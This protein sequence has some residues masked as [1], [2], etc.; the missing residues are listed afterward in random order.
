MKQSEYDAT[1]KELE[2]ALAELKK[3]NVEPDNFEY[4]T[5][6]APYFVDA[7]GNVSSHRTRDMEKIG[8]AFN[9]KEHAQTKADYMLR[10]GKMQRLLI[11]F[12]DGWEPDWGSDSNK[13]IV[14]WDVYKKKWETSLIS[15]V[16]YPG[17]I[18]FDY[19]RVHELLELVNKH[20]PNGL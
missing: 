17:S 3:V 15:T 16:E 8:N 4:L 9:K 2:A 13:G 11:E 7:A 10:V 19:S 12:N 20:F 1:V 14:W 6:Q 18:Y 5:G